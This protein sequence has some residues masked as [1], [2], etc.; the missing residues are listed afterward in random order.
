MRSGIASVYSELRDEL[1]IFGGL[2]LDQ[3]NYVY[4]SGKYLQCK[5]RLLHSTPLYMKVQCN[6]L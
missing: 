4:I 5:D 2:T 3:G 1:Y 6:V